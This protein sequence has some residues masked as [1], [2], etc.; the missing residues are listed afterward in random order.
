MKSILYLF[1]GLLILTSCRK[2][3]SQVDN[4]E[5][6][7]VEDGS[8]PSGGTVFVQYDDYSNS[9][10][11]VLLA[12]DAVTGKEKWE[13]TFQSQ[14]LS[15]GP[16]CVAEGTVFLLTSA[17]DCYLFAFDANTGARKWRTR[18][19]LDD[20]QDAVCCYSKG[21]VFVP[22]GRFLYTID[23]ANGSALWDYKLGSDVNSP[24]SNGSTVF[25]NDFKNMYAFDAET[26]TVKWQ[27][28]LVQSFDYGL[29]V[30]TSAPSLRDGILYMCPKDSGLIAIDTF[31]SRIGSC[32]I[33]NMNGFA[34]PCSNKTTT[35]TY[36][37]YDQYP[38][39]GTDVYAID[40]K[41]L[42]QKW[43]FS[44]HTSGSAYPRGNPFC[45]DK[46]VFMGVR[47]TLYSLNALDGSV[48][49]KYNAPQETL[50]SPCALGPVVFMT[51][52]RSIYAINKSTGQLRWKVTPGLTYYAKISSPV[53]LTDNGLAVH[54]TESGMTQ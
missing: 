6:K 45:T 16:V 52:N 22:T 18:L 44:V 21:K 2:Q 37:Y 17:P 39:S 24:V 27:R 50:K 14:S 11:S 9:Y 3:T 8:A 13:F 30:P 51:T 1:V 15:I 25:C 7:S 41:T 5:S 42:T 53:I 31:G 40:T 29:Q 23:A 34:S 36:G 47:D 4:I 43:K 35:F 46:D 54:P 19:R 48:Q 10:F 20:G 38:I 12:L 32:M 33:P 28:A 26:G 49:W